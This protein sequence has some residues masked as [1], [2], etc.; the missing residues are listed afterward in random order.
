MSQYSLLWFGSSW[1]VDK[2]TILTSKMTG[3]ELSNAHHM[4][5]MICRAQT[6]A[7]ASCCFSFVSS[8]SW[9][10]KTRLNKKFNTWWTRESSLWFH[11]ACT[12]KAY[13]WPS[14]S[15]KGFHRYCMDAQVIIALTIALPFSAHT[16][17]ASSRDCPAS[18][19]F[20]EYVSSSKA[21]QMDASLEWSQQ[22][23]SW[24][25]IQAPSCG[26]SHSWEIT[27][28]PSLLSDQNLDG[29]VMSSMLAKPEHG[30][31]SSVP[32]H[33]SMWF[34]AIVISCQSLQ[35]LRKLC[36][37]NLLGALWRTHVA[38]EPN[39]M[40]TPCRTYPLVIPSPQPPFLSD[41]GS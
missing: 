15:S 2:I 14:G 33:W 38:P 3:S 8:N 4:S 34:V 13:Q 27:V 5:V 39:A 41:Q 1:P 26:M 21:L 16:K 35:N 19:T 29:Y 6:S 18:W 23:L 25:D 20:T 10:C 31:I 37:L 7:E 36:L 40:A 28:L 30:L 11:D 22:L 32:E 9:R 12:A 24:R 17:A